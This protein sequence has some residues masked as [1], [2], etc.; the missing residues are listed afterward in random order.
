MDET[1]TWRDFY[2]IEKTEEGY[3]VADIEDWCYLATCDT[4]EEA[5][6]EVERIFEGLKKIWE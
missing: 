2:E 5:L 4:Y 3:K 6:W 1:L